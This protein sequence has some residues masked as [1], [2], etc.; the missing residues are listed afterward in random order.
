MTIYTFTGIVATQNCLMV[1]ASTPQPL[2][3]CPRKAYGDASVERMQAHFAP[4]CRRPGRVAEFVSINDSRREDTTLGF[5]HTTRTRGPQPLGGALARAPDLNDS[6][7]PIYWVHVPKCGS[8][9]LNTFLASRRVCSGWPACARFHSGDSVHDFFVVFPHEVYC[10]GQ[11]SRPL[12]RGHSAIGPRPVANLTNLTT[13]VRGLPCYQQVPFVRAPARERLVILLRQPEQRLLSAF[14][15][16]QH[17][18]TPK[19]RGK[20]AALAYA[21]LMAGCAVRMLT[22]PP[23]VVSACSLVHALPHHE[24]KPLPSRRDAAWAI[25]RLRNEFSFVGLTEKFELSV[26]LFQAKLGTPPP[27]GHDQIALI[28]QTRTSTRQSIA[29]RNGSRS[30]QYDV[31]VLR[32]WTDTI[33]GPLYAEAESIFEADIR[34]W[35]LSLIACRRR[36]CQSL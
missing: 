9:F 12:I 32:G 8:S 17:M 6:S 3:A 4:R 36:T 15:Y 10:P 27:C 7:A 19:Q 35:D 26:C 22:Q 2:P 16:N 31:S 11:I 30:A 25:R 24:P 5:L 29:A 14:F 13:I 20:D 23:S 21:R 1:S 28:A 33:D 34:A 18:L